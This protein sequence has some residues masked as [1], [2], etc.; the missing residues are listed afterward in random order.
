M[1]GWACVRAGGKQQGEVA[2]EGAGGKAS[3][4]NT[5]WGWRPINVSQDVW[6]RAGGVWE[7]EKAG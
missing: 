7:R 1:S 3:G 4:G 5:Q 6:V 2:C